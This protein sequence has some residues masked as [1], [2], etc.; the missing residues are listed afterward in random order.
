M[1][2]LPNPHVFNQKI[3]TEAEDVFDDVEGQDADAEAEEANAPAKYMEL[4][5]SIG[6]EPDEVVQYKA[7]GS[8][9]C[10]IVSAFDKPSLDS[11]KLKVLLANNLDMIGVRSNRS[12]EFWFSR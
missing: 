3:L 8:A 2:K 9:E 6:F 4:F 10:V 12:W 11:S 5:K 1:L 7:H